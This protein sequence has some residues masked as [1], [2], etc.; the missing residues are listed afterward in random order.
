MPTIDGFI[1]WCEHQR[2]DYVNQLEMLKSG[3]MRT[4][5]GHGSTAVGTTAE[6]IE[7]VQRYIA[8]LDGLL[9][10]RSH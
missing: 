5:S 2:T 3:R 1:S 4:G 8:E 9:A 7:R 6:S 10:K